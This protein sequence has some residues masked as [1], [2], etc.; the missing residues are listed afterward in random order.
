M[1]DQP[2][3]DAAA[4]HDNGRRDDDH[5]RRISH[6]RRFTQEALEASLDDVEAAHRLLEIG[7]QSH[8]TSK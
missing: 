3:Q 2:D 5:A 4:D 7:N 8:V 1:V 6:R